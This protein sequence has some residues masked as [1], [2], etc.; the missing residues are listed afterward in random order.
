M[1]IHC[2]QA[3]ISDFCELTHKRQRWRRDKEVKQCTENSPIVKR[4]ERDI[5]RKDRETTISNEEPPKTDEEQLKKMREQ[6]F[7]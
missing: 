5:V 6:N 2:R 1:V 4:Q 3:T 7:R